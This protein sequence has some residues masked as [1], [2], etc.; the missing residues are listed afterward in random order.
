MT[1]KTAAK[2][3]ADKLTS[4]FGGEA[5]ITE[6]GDAYIVHWGGLYDWPMGLGYALHCEIADDLP[7]DQR[8]YRGDYKNLDLK[9]PKGILYEPYGA[10][11]MYVTRD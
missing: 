4:K 1:P 7:A 5:E 9:T 10:Y 2:K 3:L 11:S 8:Q 6:Y